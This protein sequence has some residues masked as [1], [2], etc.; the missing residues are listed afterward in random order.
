MTWRGAAVSLSISLA[1]I[2]E[3]PT[4]EVVVLALPEYTVFI[5]SQGGKQLCKARDDMQLHAEDVEKVLTE[6]HVLS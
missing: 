1:A 5:E 2:I 4:D 3:E 6:T